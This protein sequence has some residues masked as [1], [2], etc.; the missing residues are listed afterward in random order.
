MR[1]KR[2]TDDYIEF[3][4]GSLI[5]FLHDQELSE[6]NYADFKQ[7]DDMA[8]EI[9]FTEP[10]VFEECEYGFRFGNPPVNMFFIPCYSRQ[11]GYYSD[12]IDIVYNDKFVIRNMVCDIY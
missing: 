3:D 5:S 7:L 8:K 11:N 4:N 1:I 6:R 12:K 9:D 2:I 10:L